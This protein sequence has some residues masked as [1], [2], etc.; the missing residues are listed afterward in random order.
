MAVELEQ[1]PVGNLGTGGK[2]ANRDNLT[3]EVAATAV[4][5]GAMFRHGGVGGG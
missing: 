1:C 3:V 4:I 2:I 5:E